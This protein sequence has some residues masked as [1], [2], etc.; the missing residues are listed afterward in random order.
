M[1]LMYPTGLTKLVNKLEL[2]LPFLDFNG[3]FIY[4]I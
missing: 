4:L 2:L 1:Q 3:T